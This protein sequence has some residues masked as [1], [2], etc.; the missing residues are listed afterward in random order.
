MPIKMSVVLCL[1]ALLIG[2]GS[3]EPSRQQTAQSLMPEKTIG[4]VL[5]EHTASL[6]ALPGVL[7]AAEGRCDGKPCIKVYVREKTPEVLKEIPA[8]IEGY[9]ITIQETGII[10]PLGSQ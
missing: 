9:P 7:G 3:Q 10:R 1:G 2:C 6:M 5:K 4:A 8:Q